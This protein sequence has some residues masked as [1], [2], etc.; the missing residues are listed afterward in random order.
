MNIKNI[1]HNI[2]HLQKQLLSVVGLHSS[3]SVKTSSGVREKTKTSCK[4]LWGISRLSTTFIGQAF[5]FIYKQY[6]Q[7]IVQVAK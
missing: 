3:L 7:S 4:L 6:M 2:C 1:V 5:T